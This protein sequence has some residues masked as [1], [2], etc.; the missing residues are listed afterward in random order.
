MESKI[1]AR[2]GPSGFAGGGR[3][4]PH[5]R[6]QHFLHPLAR[7]GRDVQD[8]VGRAADQVHDLLGP[9]FGLGSGK[10]DLVENGDDLQVVLQGQVGVGQ[11]LGL[12]ALAGVDH[13]ERPLA[14]GQ[15]ARHLVGEVHVTGSVDEVELI[16]A[17]IP[18]LVVDAHG[19]GLDGDAPLPLDVHAVEHLLAHLPVGHGVGYLQD[20]VGQRRLAVVDVG[21]DGEVADVGKGGH[22]P[23]IVPQ[24][25]CPH[26]RGAMS[27]CS[28]R[29]V[30]GG[31]DYRARSPAAA[32]HGVDHFL[33]ARSF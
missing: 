21:D 4:A 31:I 19:L 1:S 15:T 32:P 25:P 20:A 16:V 22:G 30:P 11:R 2:A 27:A 33:A 26:G 10:I 7:L 6:F 18:G 28:G 17:P 24:R 13:Q 12:D 29:I 3:D 5:D 9:A 14:R 8:I 23:R